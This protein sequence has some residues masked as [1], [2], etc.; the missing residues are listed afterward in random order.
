MDTQ[1]YSRIL[2]VIL[3]AVVLGSC[4]SLA[5]RTGS[6]PSDADDSAK[7]QM[8]GQIIV[9]DLE[10]YH[11]APPNREVISKRAL[12]SFL[13]GLHARSFLLDGDIKVITEF[14]TK[15]DVESDIVSG[16]LQIPKLVFDLIKQRRSLIRDAVIAQ[17]DEV[18]M[19]SP[20]ER[21]V[22][23][24][25]VQPYSVSID[26]LLAMWKKR[27]KVDIANKFLDACKT[28]RGC[29][30]AADVTAS[31]STKK[32]WSSA[33]LGKKVEIEKSFLQ[34]SAETLRDFDIA[35]FKAYAQAFCPHTVFMSPDDE[36][37]AQ[38]ALSGAYVGIGIEL[39]EKADGSV[40]ISQILHGRPAESEGS[41]EVGDTLTGIGQGVGQGG[42]DI[43]DIRALPMQKILALLSGADGTQVRLAVERHLRDKSKKAMVVTVTRTSVEDDEIFVKSAVVIGRGGVR[44]GYL[45]I[46][47]FYHDFESHAAAARSVYADTEKQLRAL[48]AVGVAGV[49]LDLRTNGGGSLYE[50]LDVGGLF[51]GDHMIVQVRGSSTTESKM[52]PKRI[53]S[54]A[55]HATAEPYTGPLVV[56]TNRYTASASEIVAAALQDYS[57]A[58]VIGDGSTYGKGT[59]QDVVEFESEFSENLNRHLGALKITTKKFY[60]ITGESTQLRG[61]TPDVILPDQDTE[62]S[63]RE[64]SHEA[65]LPY[66]RIQPLPLI[67]KFPL[68]R[69]IVCAE[70]KSRARVQSSA[71][72][73]KVRENIS[74]I[75]SLSNSKFV[76]T[77]LKSVRQQRDKIEALLAVVKSVYPLSTVF[78]KLTEQPQ[79]GKIRY[80]Q[81]DDPYVTESIRVIDDL[82][83]APCSIRE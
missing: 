49:V 81:V 56:L 78:D 74:S 43:A 55:R 66:D 3:V 2:G 52:E 35:Y 14:A 38:S 18:S 21:I 33:V 31:S 8:L 59:V 48:E 22:R 79:P 45:R 4:P 50:A 47:E 67:Q 25:T 1:K 60:R 71:R 65:A 19:D 9:Q 42:E 63:G 72:F 68:A 69:S 24:E 36:A 41:L 29:S 82:R 57:R 39:T 53:L 16:D 61:V 70:A 6:Q 30:P 23:D 75:E 11:Y 7:V 44:Y 46:P 77:D 40:E 27:T 80:S 73:S 34:A 28:T 83:R 32:T 76:S 20:P 10:K 58:V 64:S 54:L 12:E 15:H 5:E 62:S 17:P 13:N 37:D 26:D 51:L